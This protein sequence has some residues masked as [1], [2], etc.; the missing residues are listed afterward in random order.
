MKTE[1]LMQSGI[2]H[3][4]EPRHYASWDPP[5]VPRLRGETGGGVSELLHR[6]RLAMTPASPGSRPGFSRMLERVLRGRRT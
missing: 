3:S 6:R 5:Q 4:G 2:L 1:R